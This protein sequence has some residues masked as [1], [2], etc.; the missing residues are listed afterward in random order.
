M[1]LHQRTKEER[2]EIAI[3]SEEIIK[4]DPRVT[5]KK[6]SS[7]WGL[8]YNGLYIIRKE[9]GLP[10]TGKYSRKGRRRIE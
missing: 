7:R 3:K 5:L 6:L 1:S 4:K 10:P 2:R 8:T 9:N